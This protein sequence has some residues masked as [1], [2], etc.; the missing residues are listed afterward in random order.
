[1]GLCDRVRPFIS[2]LRIYSGSRRLRYASLLWETT[3]SVMHICKAPLEAKA[4]TPAISSYKAPTTTA[5]MLTG[6]V[7]VWAM[8]LR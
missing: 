8:E 7:A 2:Q 5:M 6:T 3:Q 1:M 4:P